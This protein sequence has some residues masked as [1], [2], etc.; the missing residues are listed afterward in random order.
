[1][2]FDTDDFHET[3]HRLDLLERLKDANPAFKMTVFAVPAYCP[4]SF[5]NSLPD[6]IEVAMHGWDHG[7]RDCS[8]A[9]EAQDW[10]YEQAMD[11]L[12]AASGRFVDGFKAPGW[13]ISDGTYL[14]LEELGW[15]VADQHYNDH[16]RPAGIRVHCEG[17]GDHVH[18]HVQNVCGNGL[19]ETFPML[20]DLVAAAESFQWISEVV[21][22]SPL[23]AAA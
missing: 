3:N 15:W 20:L 1:M 11:V 16:R 14:A 4:E 9:N 8:N 18:T 19:A 2:I 23:A 13:Q 5:L 7:G 12:V 17:D 21:N 22:R 6:W 10:T